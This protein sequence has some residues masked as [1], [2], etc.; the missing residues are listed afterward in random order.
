MFQS[1]LSFILR[2]K[3]LLNVK[4]LHIS[5]L[6]RKSIVKDLIKIN[7]KKYES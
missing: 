7:A 1:L 6:I 4:K 2:S 5:R 3:W